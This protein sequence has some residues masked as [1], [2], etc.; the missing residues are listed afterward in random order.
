MNFRSDVRFC[1]IGVVVYH[2]DLDILSNLLAAV[3][4]DGSDIWLFLNSPLMPEAYEKLRNVAKSNLIFINEGKNLGLGVAYNRLVEAV[5]AVGAQ[6]LLIFDQDSS[7]TPSIMSQLC[8]AYESLC[9]VGERPA[10]VAPLPVSVDSEHFKSPRIFR[11]YAKV[12]GS[13]RSAEFVI[14]SGSLLD[15]KAFKQIGRFREDFFIDA[16]DIEWCF[17]SWSRGYSCWIDSAVLM[18]HRLGQG[19][20]RVPIV[21]MLLTRQLPSRF[22]TYIRNQVAM[23]RLPHTPLCWKL[24]ILPYLMAQCVIYLVVSQGLRRNIF[25]AFRFGIVD[26]ILLRLGV[27]QRDQLFFDPKQK[28]PG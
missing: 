10:V 28:L 18:P 26:G 22:Y 14:S 12:H 6:K 13:L 27:G 25:R 20:I 8:T 1:A 3:S 5:I 21:N 4:G 17:R 2:P 23:L 19:V 11:K 24:R 16:I 7:P 9:A 15:L